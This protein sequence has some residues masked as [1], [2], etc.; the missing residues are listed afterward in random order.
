MSQAIE[1][2][3]AFFAAQLPDP[4]DQQQALDGS[5]YFTGG[6]PAEVVIRLTASSIIVWEYAA[7][8]EG[9]RTLAPRPVRVGSVAWPRI[10]A[11]QAVAAVQALVE[12]A[13]QSRRSKYAICSYCERVTPPEQMHDD[14]SCM[15]CAQKHLGVVY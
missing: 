6:D 15:S 11:A 12:A 8:W 10:P 3:L 13:R 7:Q 9:P 1:E 4:V 5:T 14:D 2:W